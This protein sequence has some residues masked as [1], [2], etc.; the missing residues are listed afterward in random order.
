MLYNFYN[1]YSQWIPA[2][3]P[4]RTKV[5]PLK[6]FSSMIKTVK[7]IVVKINVV[8]SPMQ[9]IKTQLYLNIW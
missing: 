1:P 3:R 2:L 7:I 5:F 9:P 6:Q 8:D 4:P